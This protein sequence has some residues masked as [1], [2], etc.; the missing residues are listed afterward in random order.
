MSD[1]RSQI[2]QKHLRYFYINKKKDCKLIKIAKMNIWYYPIWYINT[3]SKRVDSTVCLTFT[4][5][6]A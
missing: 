4:N 6:A 5:V 2:L 3:C 1:Y